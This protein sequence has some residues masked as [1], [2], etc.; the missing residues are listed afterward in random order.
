VRPLVDRLGFPTP[1]HPESMA[2]ELPD[3]DEL[4]LCALADALWPG[5]EYVQ[6]VRQHCPWLG[7]A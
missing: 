2:A 3:A 5:G 1:A 7:G 4:W 6:I